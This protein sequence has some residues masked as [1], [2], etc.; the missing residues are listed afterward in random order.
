MLEVSRDEVPSTPQTK[1]APNANQETQHHVVYDIR[2]VAL[3]RLEAFQDLLLV[4][5]ILSMKDASSH[6]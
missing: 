6:T 3:M 5:L 1:A 2:F 4:F